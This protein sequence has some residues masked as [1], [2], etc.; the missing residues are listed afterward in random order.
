[1]DLFVPGFLVENAMLKLFAGMVKWFF[2]KITA[3]FVDDYDSVHTII[4]EFIAS[5]FVR[6]LCTSL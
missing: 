6:L 1:M 5:N 2:E 3:F 4:Y